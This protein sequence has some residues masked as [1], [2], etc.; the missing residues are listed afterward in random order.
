MTEGIV[1]EDCLS[2]HSYSGNIHACQ[3]R[4]DSKD[5]PYLKYGCKYGSMRL[6]TD[7]EQIKSEIYN[8][9]PVI[10]GLIIYDDFDNYG[11]GIYETGPDAYEE[12]GH[13]V[14]LLGWGEDGD[15]YL[16]WIA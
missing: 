7:Y 4:C 11:S 13:A 6:Q 9:G 15:G 16:Y 1:S 10:A 3:Y 14:T 8:H 5:T 12:G 2:Y